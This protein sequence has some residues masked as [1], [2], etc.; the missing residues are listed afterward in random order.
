MPSLEIP[1]AA[2]AAAAAIAFLLSLYVCLGS[3]PPSTFYFLPSLVGGVSYKSAAALGPRHTHTPD[4]DAGGAVCTVHTQGKHIPGP[5]GKN[6][7][8]NSLWPSIHR[9]LL[10]LV[11]RTTRLPAHSWV[12]G[13]PG[14]EITKSNLLSE[15]CDAVVSS[16][17]AERC[18]RV[19]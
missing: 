12:L 19:G 6:S 3:Q 16:R 11:Y 15:E 5:Y 4:F 1:I 2:A 10:F 18:E 14:R 9:Q 7:T 17:V 13:S 8:P